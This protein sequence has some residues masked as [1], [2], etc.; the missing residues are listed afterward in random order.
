MI[1][2]EV[3]MRLVRNAMEPASVRLSYPILDAHIGLTAK[4]PGCGTHGIDRKQVGANASLSTRAEVGPV[5]GFCGTHGIDDGHVGANAC[6][7]AVADWD[8]N[9]LSVPFPNLAAAISVTNN[10]SL[11]CIGFSF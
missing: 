8:D 6:C 11:A 2:I 10:S 5:P 4:A 3:S 9:I 7:C 1:V